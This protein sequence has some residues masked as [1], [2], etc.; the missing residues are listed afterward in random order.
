[1]VRLNPLSPEQSRRFLQVN[2]LGDSDKLW[3][4]IDFGGTSQGISLT[5][6]QAKA[7]IQEIKDALKTLEPDHQDF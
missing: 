6:P 1:M 2:R 3:F 5:S 7:L 4:W